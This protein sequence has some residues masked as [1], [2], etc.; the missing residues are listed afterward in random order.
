MFSHVFLGVAD[1]DRA[2]AFYTPLMAALHLPQRFCDPARPWAGWQS[3]P[4]PRPLFVIAHPFDAMAATAG[5][6]Q[7]TAFLAASRGTVDEAHAAALAHGGVC[8]GAP[9]LRPQ[10]YEHYYGAYFRD[11]DG[12]K[13]CVVC[14]E[15]P[16]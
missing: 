12:N 1:F 2:L 4:G 15:E 3:V 5:N 8:E 11:P 10:Y 9:G 6:G 13:L 16:R 14:H 7:M